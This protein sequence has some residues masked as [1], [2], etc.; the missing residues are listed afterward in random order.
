MTLNPLDPCQ[1][2]GRDRVE[3]ANEQI[4]RPAQ[5]GSTVGS[6]HRCTRRQLNPDRKPRSPGQHDDGL[7]CQPYSRSGYGSTATASTAITS[8][9][10]LSSRPSASPPSRTIASAR[11]L[12]SL[13]ES[14]QQSDLVLLHDTKPHAVAVHAET[15]LDLTRTAPGAVMGRRLLGKCGL[16]IAGTSRG[17][18]VGGLGD[19]SVSRPADLSLLP[20]PVDRLMTTLRPRSTVRPCT[21][22]SALSVACRSTR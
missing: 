9:A 17:G 15:L 1:R 22:A 20:N 18:G 6:N 3:V 16:S 8:S 12:A 7:N 4:D 5:L 21:R 14:A 10:Q 11:V 19:L 2:L 13:S